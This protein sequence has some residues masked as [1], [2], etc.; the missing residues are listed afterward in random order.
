MDLLPHALR[1]AAA[2][3]PTAAPPPV[4]V[5]GARGAL[6]SAVVE[7]LLA[8][9]AFS[10]VRVLVTQPFAS[11]ARGLRTVLPEELAAMQFARPATLALAVFDRPRRAHGREDAFYAPAPRELA[12]LAAQWHACG[13]RDLVVVMPHASGSMPAALAAGLASL[14]EQTVAALGFERVAILRPAAPPHASAS[15]GLQRLA[16]LVLAQLRIMVPQTLQP[17][18]ARHVARVA[19]EVARQ[20]GSHAAGTRVLAPDRVW[21]AAQ[22]PDAGPLV[23][24]WLAGQPG[25]APNVGL[26]RL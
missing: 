5:A 6:G 14:D 3:A 8:S 20:L 4:L 13:V 2:P 19:V 1:Q 25:P 7:R 16:D 11:T 12:G 22:A 23:E 18:R 26:G 17:V 24:A 15:S 21:Q 9:G 10:E